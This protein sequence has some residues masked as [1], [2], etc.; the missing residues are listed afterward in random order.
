MTLRIIGG[1]HR[2]RKLFSLKGCATRPTPERVREALFNILGT[3]VVDCRFL[4]LFAGTGAVGLEALSRGASR[5]TFVENAAPALGVLKRNLA[6]L[7]GRERTRL[8]RGDVY[9]Y[10]GAGD[11]DFIFTSPPFPEI[12]RMSHLGRN[13][14][15]QAAPGAWW[16]LQH[17][18]RYEISGIDDTWERVE[19]RIYGTNALSFFRIQKN[20]VSL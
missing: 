20:P 4:D 12:D 10:R 17:P 8:V 6:L 1:E 2:A 18:K 14:G 13:L 19:T 7:G 5:V 15:V 11:E 3:Q 9:T 16:I